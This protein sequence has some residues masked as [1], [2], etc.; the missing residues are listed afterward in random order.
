MSDIVPYLSTA[1][2]PFMHTKDTLMP[3]TPLLTGRVAVVTGGASGIGRATAVL[4]ARHGA[5]VFTGDYSPLAENAALF[6]EWKI[7]ESP[8]DVRREADL[9]RLID[10]A[11]D[12]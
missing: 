4:L 12:A 8:C 6:A 1:H 3:S 7:S 10:G 11:A 2:I 9:Q 5:R